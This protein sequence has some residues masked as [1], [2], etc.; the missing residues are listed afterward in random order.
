MAP[1]FGDPYPRAAY[2]GGSPASGCTHVRA[3]G[4]CQIHLK[5][6]SVGYRHWSC[7]VVR[8][9]QDQTAWS[10]VSKGVQHLISLAVAPE[11]SWFFWEEAREELFSSPASWIAVMAFLENEEHCLHSWM[12]NAICNFSGLFTCHV[13]CSLFPYTP[14]WSLSW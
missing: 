3:G 11:K 12:S 5:V 14:K 2:L 1:H 6:F 13:N 9:P 4:G 7:F 8:M 10:L